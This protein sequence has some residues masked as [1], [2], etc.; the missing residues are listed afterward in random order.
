[1]P[2]MT[3]AVDF[4]HAA[5]R[6]YSDGDLLM[7]N[8]RYA[9]AGQLYGFTAECGIKWL[10]VWKGYPSDPVTGEI[11]ERKKKFR[12]HIHELIKNINMLSTYLEGRGASKYLAMIPSIR[13]FSDWKTDHRYYV[14]SALPSSLP[15][16]QK[17]AREIMQMLNEAIL[18]GEPI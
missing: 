8:S 12:V 16:W 17:A 18:D 5:N 7:A 15:D 9:N 11:V 2:G 4:R 1:M 14:D 10:L 3:K 6:H 13:N